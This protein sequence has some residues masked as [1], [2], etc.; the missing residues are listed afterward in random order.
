MN[1]LLLNADEFL[2]AQQIAALK[3]GMG[4]AEMADLNT[5]TLEGAQTSVSQ[6]LGEASMMPFLAERRLIIVRGL[7]TSLDR[8]MSASKATDSAAYVDAALLLNGLNDIS[9]VTDLVLIEEKGIDKRRHLWKG[10][11]QGDGGSVKVPGIADLIA[12]GQLVISEQ[13]TPDARDMPAWI[14]K[15]AQDKDIAI[16]GHAI[17]IL[18][19]YVGANLRQMDNELEKLAAYASGRAVSGEDV[20]LLVAD[21]SEAVIWNLTDALSQRNSRLAMQTVYELRRN[22]ANP[23]YL[24]TMMARQYRII[25]KVKDAMHGGLRSEYEIAKRVKESPYPVKKSMGHARNYTFDELDTIM[26]KLLSADF[27]MKTGADPDTEIDL[28][29]AGLT[30]KPAPQGIISR[31]SPRITSMILSHLSLTHYRNY[32]HLELDFDGG[33]TLFQGENAQGKTNLLEAIY[34][35]ATSK[36]VHAQHEREVVGWGASDEPIPY[37]RILGEV[38]DHPDSLQRPLTLEVLL[39]Q[40]ESGSNFKKQVK[41]NGVSK[42]S[43]DLV[44]T[45]RAVLFLPEDIKLVSGGPGERRRY[46]D[47]A[48]CQID[49]EYCRTLS[50]FQKVITQRNSLLKALREQG[51]NPGAVG[52]AAQLDFWDERLVTQGSRVMARRAAY[53]SELEAIAAQRHSD[54]TGGTEQLALQYVPSFNLGFLTEPDYLLLKEGSLGVDA[55][56]GRHRLLSNGEMAAQYQAKLQRRRAREIAAGNTLYGP[57]RDDLRL[58]ANGRDQRLYGSRG[59]QRTAA[60]SL[61]LA[62]VH[63]MAEAGG[64]TPLLLLDDVMSELDARRRST[65]LSALDGV[66]Q[67]IL[68]TTD[69]GDFTPEFRQ[70]AQLFQ[71]SGASVTPIERG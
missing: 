42:R 5:A 47:I 19:E 27:A 65:L 16:E 36:P 11:T 56:S 49:R 20:R 53:I 32:S 33:L 41:I 7:L 26:E 25:I 55:Y 23:F 57:H 67:A 39:T 48:L 70:R 71:V 21:A 50:A 63:T 52:T 31:I 3:A 24:L 38:R 15:R 54:L 45:L 12:S 51:A 58:L 13:S 4:D 64:S 62:E 61:K 29:I 43:M 2:A 69:W 30:Q 6:I 59:Q 60:L 10:F 66:R 44:G 1:Y 37:C 18:A 22:D 34:F 40:S 68:T 14:R 8:R 17:Q 28:L 35:L 9:D 46:L